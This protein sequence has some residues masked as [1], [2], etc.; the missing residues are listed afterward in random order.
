MPMIPPKA[1][2]GPAS[3]PNAE[4]NISWKTG[5]IWSALM[6]VTAMAAMM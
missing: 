6:I 4:L 1:A 3:M 5:T 2:S